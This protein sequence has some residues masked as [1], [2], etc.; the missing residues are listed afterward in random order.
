MIIVQ[1]ICKVLFLHNSVTVIL[2]EFATYTSNYDSLLVSLLKIFSSR[3]QIQNIAKNWSQE[4][5][6]DR[7]GIGG[8]IQFQ[9]KFATHLLTIHK[10]EA[11]FSH[12]PNHHLLLDNYKLQTFCFKLTK[13][14][15][16]QNYKKTKFCFKNSYQI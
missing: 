16:D 15:C 8:L 9:S 5:E 2:H 14:A 6:Q 1:S 7:E 13:C 10:I 4:L 3:Y 11:H 12:I